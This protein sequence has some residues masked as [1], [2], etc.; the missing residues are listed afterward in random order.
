MTPE[1][2]HQRLEKQLKNLKREAEDRVFSPFSKKPVVEKWTERIEQYDRLLI[3]LQTW[4]ILSPRSTEEMKMYKETLRQVR[5]R[6]EALIS[7]DETN[8]G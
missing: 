4:N 1:S 8:Y 6:I 2:E 3:R 7:Q 5:E